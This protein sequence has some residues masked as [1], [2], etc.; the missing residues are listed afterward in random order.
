MKYENLTSVKE[1][2]YNF[3]EKN[4]EIEEIKLSSTIKRDLNL[5]LSSNVRIN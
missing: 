1:F 5:L 2:I 4:K 3:P